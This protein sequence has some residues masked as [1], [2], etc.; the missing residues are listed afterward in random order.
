[1]IVNSDVSLTSGAN[2]VEARSAPLAAQD[3]QLRHIGRLP[4]FIPEDRDVDVFGEPGDQTEGPGQRSTPF[5]QQTGLPTA[6]LLNGVS[7]VQQTP[8]SFST[9][10][11]AVPKR[12]VVPRNRSRRSASLAAM[13]SWKDG[14]NR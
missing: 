2:G 9:F 3:G 11:T 1:M 5:E 7:R 6:R 8:K 14:F 12:A 10:W 13:T 4:Q